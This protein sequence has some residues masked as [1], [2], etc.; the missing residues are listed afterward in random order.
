MQLKSIQLKHTLHFADLYLEFP[1]TFAPATLI[2]GQ[3]SSGKTGLLKTL[4]QSLT[5]FAAHLKEPRTT[6]L[7]MPDQNIMLGRLQSKI[8]I[9][10]RF[11]VEVGAFEASSNQQESDP[12]LY[13]L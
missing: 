5:W 13:A 1:D 7:V 11:S 4:H 9:C 2:I 10:I 3:Q 6:G 8:D 12:H